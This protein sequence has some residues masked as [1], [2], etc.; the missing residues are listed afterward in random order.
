MS[1]L[2]TP[3]PDWHGLLEVGTQVLAHW[4]DKSLLSTSHPE[5]DA[6]EGCDNG[7]QVPRKISP[8]S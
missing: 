5:I 1:Q 7:T 6:A 8:C 4:K 3:H 2:Y